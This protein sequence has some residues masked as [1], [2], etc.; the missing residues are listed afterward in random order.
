VELGYAT[1]TKE[2]Q[3][4][5]SDEYR[6]LLVTALADGISVFSATMNPENQLKALPPP[7]P[8]PPEPVKV[9]PP[10]KKAEPP[11]KKK[12][13]PRRRKPAQRS[14]PAERSKPATRRNRK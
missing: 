8:P 5:N 1:N 2:A 6:N 7:P 11:A 13:T 10:K 3:A 12:S 4:L 9:E 14:K